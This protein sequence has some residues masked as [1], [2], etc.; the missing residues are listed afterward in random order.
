MKKIILLSLIVLG[1]G[2]T[3]TFTSCSKDDSIA[4]VIILT[5]LANI[6][7]PLNSPVWT[8]L[9]ATATDDEDGTLTV[10][11]DASLSNPNVNKSGTYIITYTATDKAGN[12]AAGTRTIRVYN[13][14]EIFA[15][16]YNNCVDTCI[17]TPPSAFS[18][19][20]IVTLSDSINRLVKINN[21]GAFGSDIGVWVKI[22]GNSTGSQIIV[23]SGQSL[24]G[25]AQITTVYPADS[26]V[27]SGNPLSTSFFIKYGWTDGTANDVC[28]TTYIR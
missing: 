3:L 21:F 22:T 19:P 15:G 17:T 7:L 25:N 6:D 2:I 13:E 18:T 20:G 5:G 24:G 26:K 9:F 28:E 16:S 12:E 1:T 10:T 27:I 4:P 11:S 14:A 23:D 8:D